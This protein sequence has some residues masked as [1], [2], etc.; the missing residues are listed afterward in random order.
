M[1][2]EAA[3]HAH[4][5]AENAKAGPLNRDDC[6]YVKARAHEDGRD[7]ACI[8]AVAP[9]AHRI[10]GFR[11][12]ETL[13]S[14]L[15]RRARRIVEV[16]ERAG[17]RAL[18]LGAWGCGYFRNDLRQ[19]YAAFEEALRGAAITEVVWALPDLTHRRV[20]GMLIADVPCHAT[21]QRSHPR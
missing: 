19:V 15:T 12:D 14:T 9:H 5:Y 1:R 21:V 13:Q 3:E 17:H 8:I 4:W 16:A 6:L 2:L 10:V 11:R 20:L 18:V 7:I